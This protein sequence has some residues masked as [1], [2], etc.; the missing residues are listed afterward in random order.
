MLSFR[1][2][3]RK[4]VVDAHFGHSS[5]WYN[6]YCDCDEDGMHTTKKL[7]EVITESFTDWMMHKNQQEC[8]NKQTTI[9]KRQDDDE[10][11]LEVVAFNF[12]L[13]NAKNEYVS[14][15]RMSMCDCRHLRYRLVVPDITSFGSFISTR[16]HSPANQCHETHK[17]LMQDGLMDNMFGTV[18]SGEY[19][20]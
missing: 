4:I 14:P 18:R 3:H 17:D 12:D 7:C 2:C 1:E 11:P 8:N 5:C 20:V 16:G 9:D 13:W 15:L 19:Q 10:P 6:K